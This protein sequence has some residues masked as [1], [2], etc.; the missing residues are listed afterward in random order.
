[1]NTYQ[2]HKGNLND[3]KEKVLLCMTTGRLNFRETLN[4]FEENILLYG[5]KEKFEMTL[6]INYDVTYASL[7]PDNFQYDSKIGLSVL[8]FGDEFRIEQE[9]N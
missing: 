8:Y 9:K 7:L 3:S 5:L 1:M 4:M 6:A 2:K